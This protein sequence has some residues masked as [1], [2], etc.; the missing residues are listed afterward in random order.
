MNWYGKTGLVLEGGGM[1]GAFGKPLKN[2]RI[3]DIFRKTED[4][5]SVTETFDG[6]AKI[7]LKNPEYAVYVVSRSNKYI[8]GILRSD[9]LSFI[10]S[11]TLSSNVIAEDIMRF[12]I[13]VL[14]TDMP[15]IDGVK[16]FAENSQY[17]SMPIVNSANEF[18]GIV[19]R[20]DIF[21]G[22]N[23]ILKRDK[24]DRE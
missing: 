4:T 13:P 22:F 8:G 14:K 2:I 3:K 9:I 11:K 5:V 15:L 12:D 21:M 24:L 16:I 23:E 10:K 20:N 6:V 19:N 7:F 1:R 18:Y 17:E